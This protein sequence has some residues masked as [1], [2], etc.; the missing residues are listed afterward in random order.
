[1]YSERK[2]IVWIVCIVVD[3]VLILRLW[4]LVKRKEST[5]WSVLEHKVCVYMYLFGGYH[6]LIVTRK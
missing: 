3:R 5:E 2:C 4:I 1:M 6:H